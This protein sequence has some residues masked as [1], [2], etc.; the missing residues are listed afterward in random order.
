MAI[1]CERCGASAPPLTTGPFAGTPDTLDYCAECG[2]N[3]CDRCMQEG[4]CDDVPARSGLFE[5]GGDEE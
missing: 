5:D 4:C 1:R 2:K 3:L